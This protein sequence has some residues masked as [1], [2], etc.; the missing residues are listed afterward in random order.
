M[1]LEAA[2]A[3][4]DAVMVEGYVLYPYRAS[5]PKNRYRW[6]FGVLAP[7]AWSDAG[8]CEPWWLDAQV[9]VALGDATRITGRLRFLHVERRRVERLDPDGGYTAV[10]ALEHDGE[11]AVAWDEGV[12]REIGFEIAPEHPRDV[13]IDLAYHREVA[14][15]AGGRVI[16]ERCALTGR[17]A[18]AAERVPC[19]R[20]LVR[21][22]VRVENTTPWLDVIAPRERAIAGA[23]VS[24][25]VL[26]G[27]D[28][29]ELLSL[30]DPPAWAR[31]AAAACR[32]HRT[33]PVLAADGVVLAS[34]IALPDYPR[35]APESTR[36]LCDAA[37]IDELLALRTKTLT[38]DEKRW[39]RATDARAAAIVDGAEAMPDAVLA[40]LH[41][42]ARDV[43]DAEMIPKL[44][45]GAHVRLAPRPHGDA[46]D[47]LLAGMAATIADIRVDVD[48]TVYYAVTIDDDPAAELHR[49]YGRFHYFRADEVVPG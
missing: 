36:D 29:G 18:L 21:L 28:G 42:A 3:I 16:R 39:A 37:E 23:L 33:F 13:A 19:D 11:L 2:R 5:A 10:D 1:N 4:A 35:V 46:Q 30:I 6:T 22:T 20:P 8:G 34:P 17:I 40:R 45:R 7:R 27:V 38:D 41:G 31:D 25:H 44:T 12:C 48:G 26:L 47:L 9:L 15:V 43:R 24:T 14:G 49:W 32:S